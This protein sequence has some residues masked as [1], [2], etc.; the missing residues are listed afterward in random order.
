[1]KQVSL[2]L[3]AQTLA[4]MAVTAAAGDPVQLSAE[5]LGYNV[6]AFLC[7][8]NLERISSNSKNHQGSAYRACFEPN[9]KAKE[10]GV[11]IRTIDSF[12]WKLGD[13]TSQDAVIDGK[14]DEVLNILACGVGPNQHMCYAESMLNADFY[15]SR[16]YVTGVG[17]AT[18]TIGSGKVEMNIEQDGDIA[19]NANGGFSVSA[20][21]SIT[22][23]TTTTTIGS[24]KKKI[25]TAQASPSA[26]LGSEH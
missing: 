4:M 24:A 9:E 16:G 10:D 13:N 19:T 5:E 6:Y 3:I 11:G 1:M 18:M 7:N 15:H 21:S 26:K 14:A 22:T 20:T 25:I 8:E 2:S 17:V 23:S 12:T